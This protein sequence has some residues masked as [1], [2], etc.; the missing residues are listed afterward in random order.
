MAERPTED[1]VDGDIV[2]KSDRKVDRGPV[3]KG[4]GESVGDN[5]AKKAVEVRGLEGGGVA[6]CAGEANWFEWL[7]RVVKFN[8]RDNAVGV[9]S[10]E[11]AMV[12]VEAAV[13]ASASVE[14]SG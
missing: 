14:K 5:G 7:C 1:G 9:F 6:D 3:G 13:E 4:M 11:S 12:G 10:S 2:S 8:E